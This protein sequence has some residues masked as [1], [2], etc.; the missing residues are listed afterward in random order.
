MS[1]AHLARDG[2]IHLSERRSFALG[3][4]TASHLINRRFRKGS[5]RTQENPIG[6]F[7]YMELSPWP[8]VTGTSDFLGQNYLSFGREPG[9]VH[10]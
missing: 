2:S 8:P 5:D 4:K 10:R 1:P 7:F 3:T 6:G 9:I